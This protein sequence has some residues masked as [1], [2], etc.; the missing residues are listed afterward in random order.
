VDKIANNVKLFETDFNLLLTKSTQLDNQFQEIKYTLQQ[1]QSALNCRDQL[2]KATADQ[3][4]SRIFVLEAK[5][6]NSDSAANEAIFRF[7]ILLDSHD[8]E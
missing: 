6:K 8:A 1:V 5:C 7:K 3:Y 2:F 4:E